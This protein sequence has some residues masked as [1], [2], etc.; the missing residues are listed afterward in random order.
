MDVVNIA[1][2]IKQFLGDTWSAIK[3]KGICCNSINVSVPNSVAPRI[4]LTE[5][6]NNS[7][8]LNIDNNHIPRCISFKSIKSK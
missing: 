2:I 8:E 1:N 4:E 7:R 6:N 3:C 5:N